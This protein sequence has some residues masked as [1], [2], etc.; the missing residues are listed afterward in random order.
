MDN[1][2]QRSFQHYAL[3]RL[4]R[5]IIETLYKNAKAW[6]QAF[7]CSPA[8]LWIRIREPISLTQTGPTSQISIFGKKFHDG[9]TWPI[10]VRFGSNFVQSALVSL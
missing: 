5:K 4:P 3:L 9:L 2:Y 10:F 6:S 7:Q 1:Q 8:V